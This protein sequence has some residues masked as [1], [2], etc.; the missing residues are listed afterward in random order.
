MR[1]RIV[2]VLSVVCILVGALLVVLE[3]HKEIQVVIDNK[4]Q[5]LTTWAL[6][7]GDALRSA[8]IPIYE[9]DLVTPSL[10]SWLR[11]GDT[12]NIERAFWVVITADGE[13][14][15]LLTTERLPVNLLSQAGVTLNPEDILLVDGKLIEPTEEL[16]IA[17]SYSLQVRRATPITVND[18]GQVAQ[19][20]STARTLGEA[21][22]D[23]GIHL[24]S[25][26]Q[27]EPPSETPLEGTP[28]QVTITRSQEIEITFTEEVIQA[29]VLAS[30][31]GTAL[32]EASL[33]L[34][35][36]DF[37][38]PAEDESIPADGKIRIVHVTE[39]IIIE[40]EPLPFGVQYQAASEVDLDTQAV[41][42][43]GEYGLTAQR[44]RIIYEDGVEV[45]RQTEEEWV[46]R[47]PQD[48]IIGYG[49]KITLQ[50]TKTADGP[51]TYW[52]AV[53][54]YASTYS[55]CHSGVPDKC[56]THTSSGKPVQKGVVAV[57]L[58]WYRY[59]QGLPVY[60]PNYGYGTIEDV[61]GGLPD[62][63][64]IDLGYSDD[65]WVGWGGWTTIYFLA[66]APANIMWILE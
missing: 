26:D 52:R 61:G 57:T 40:Q 43:V 66:P 12:V 15:T 3:L 23:E 1:K 20:V 41:L 37:S 9:G 47:Q 51:I 27:L 48:R 34:Q 63:Y 59:M 5:T 17:S 46:A 54:V 19:L 4:A 8:S 7:V 60:V 24:Y 30:T 33:S 36:M 42:Q 53:E 39:Q 49:T 10:D 28:I 25:G 56:Y 50:T 65:D 55:P 22:W 44:V 21:L 18:S 45:S 38:I 29:R 31:V 58:A 32:A 64:W 62:R 14:Q 2:L 35:G 11:E 13:S 6:R 16:T